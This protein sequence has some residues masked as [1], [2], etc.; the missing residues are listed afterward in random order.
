MVH[1]LRKLV[2]TLAH[3]LN[4]FS[5]TYFSLQTSCPK[6]VMQTVNTT[7][8]TRFIRNDEFQKNSQVLI[9]HQCEFHGLCSDGTQG[10]FSPPNWLQA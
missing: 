4:Q 10:L 1:S 6:T 9:K 8:C 3:F 7:I 2:R 5:F